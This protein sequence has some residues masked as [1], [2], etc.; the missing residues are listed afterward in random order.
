MFIYQG[1]YDEC[2]ARI[3]ATGNVSWQKNAPHVIEVFKALKGII[4]RA[5][6]GSASLWF[7]ASNQPDSMRLQDDLYATTDVV[8]REATQNQ[9]ARAFHESKIGLW[10]AF[11]DTFATA[12]QEMLM[13]GLPVVAA[14]HGLA[15]EL[16]VWGVSGVREQV[17]A[18][19]KLINESDEALEE[20]ANRISKWA[21]EHASYEAF[22]DQLKTVLKG[23][24]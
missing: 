11:H 13:A 3:V 10:V 18:I 8:I 4:E 24:Y 16:P 1:K 23:V 9:V 5:Y 2:R 20:Q 22:H 17:D 19:K 21:K 14:R 6:I 12:A 7:D 15:S